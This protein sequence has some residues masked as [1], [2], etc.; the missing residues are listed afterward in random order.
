M[1]EECSSSKPRSPFEQ[2]AARGAASAQMIVGGKECGGKDCAG[3]IERALAPQIRNCFGGTE[4]VVDA[5]LLSAQAALFSLEL[6]TQS[7]S[8]SPMN[9]AEERANVPA[10]ERRY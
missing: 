6:D 5:S 8:L 1:R 7:T 3:E 10:V 4:H 9:R 2:V